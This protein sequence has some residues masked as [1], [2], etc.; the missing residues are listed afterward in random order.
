MIYAATKTQQGKT[1]NED[2]FLIG[3]GQI[4]YAALCDGSG[5]AQQAAKKV[6]VLFE[7]LLIEATNEQL[8]TPST[9]TK[10]IKLLDSSLLGGNQSTFLAIALLHGVAV[11]ACTGD[12]RAYLLDRD[13]E[14]RILTD[15]ATKFRLGSG[16]A[17]A[18]PIRQQLT[19]G[20]TVMLLSD[21]AWTPLGLYGL[22]K[23]VLSTIGRHFSEVPIAI[24]EA[25]GK[26]G[27]LDDMTAIAIRVR[28]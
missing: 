7:K 27:R 28:L 5:N 9:W 6:L 20:E 18:F 8:L 14:L 19:H 4:Q 16:N 24:L 12:S 1:A 25:A 21:G 15:G 2:A 13:G 23:A 3:R 10:W 11:G 26:S 17:E 22:R